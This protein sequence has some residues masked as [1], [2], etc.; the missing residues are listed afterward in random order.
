MR[1]YL[2]KSIK[3]ITENTYNRYRTAI[4][5]RLHTHLNHVGAV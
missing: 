2:K 3:F 4:H 1:R 5:I